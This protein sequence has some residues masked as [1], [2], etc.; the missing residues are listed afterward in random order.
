VKKNKKKPGE[1]YRYFQQAEYYSSKELEIA[2]MNQKY[3]F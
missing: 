3:F 2:T 1:F